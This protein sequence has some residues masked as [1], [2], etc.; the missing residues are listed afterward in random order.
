MQVNDTNP[1][2]KYLDTYKGFFFSILKGKATV[3]KILVLNKKKKT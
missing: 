2:Y 1:Y 3:L